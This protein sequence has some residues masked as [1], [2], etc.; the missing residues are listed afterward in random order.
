MNKEKV[1]EVIKH[2]FTSTKAEK[3]SWKS[4]ADDEFIVSFEGSSLILSWP[5]E[6]NRLAI[7]RA[8]A[9]GEVPDPLMKIFNRNGVEILKINMETISDYGLDKNILPH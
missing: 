3:I 2:I 1:K 4:N 6:G 9:F 7:A 8:Q 5:D